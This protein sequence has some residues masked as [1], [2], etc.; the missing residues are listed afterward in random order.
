MKFIFNSPRIRLVITLILTIAIGVLS[1]LFATEIT[2]NGDV[3]WNL[4]A[5]VQSFWFLVAASIVWIII[6]FIFLHN[7]ENLLKYADDSHC[8]AHIRKTK[9]DGYAALVKK[10]PS[11]ADLI[12]V[13]KLL[14]D[15]QVKK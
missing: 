14:K 13:S 2:P 15:L 4:T 9:L 1:S 10:D 12:G 5:K 8:L 11:K 6:H 7:D 3:E